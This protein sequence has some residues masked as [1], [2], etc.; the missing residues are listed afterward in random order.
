M[1]TE[2]ETFRLNENRGQLD[3]SLRDTENELDE[4]RKT[5][6][7]N[8]RICEVIFLLL[9]SLRPVVLGGT[10]IQENRVVQDQVCLKPLHQLHI[11][12]AKKSHFKKLIFKTSDIGK[13]T[14]Y[15]RFFVL[16]N[17][18]TSINLF[19]LCIKHLDKMS[20]RLSINIYLFKSYS[21]SIKVLCKVLLLKM[22][23]SF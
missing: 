7:V 20:K 15:L 2:E 6:Q 10:G 14:V 17:C 13:K 19:N 21:K 5:I 12:N 8:W 3:R 11:A 18:A 23:K 22:Q 9:E 4:C 1:K 16:F